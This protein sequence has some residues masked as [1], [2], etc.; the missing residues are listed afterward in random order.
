M[1]QWKTFSGIV[2]AESKLGLE[3]DDAFKLHTNKIT[4]MTYKLAWAALRQKERVYCR[5]YIQNAQP[6]WSV[7]SDNTC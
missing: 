1:T 4:C 6:F 2:L 5:P 3:P 7:A